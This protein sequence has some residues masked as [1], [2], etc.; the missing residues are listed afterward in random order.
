MKESEEK[1]KILVQTIPDI[2][3]EID[4]EGR[5]TFLS[6]AIKELGYNIIIAIL[7]IFPKDNFVPLHLYT[8]ILP[9]YITFFKLVIFIKQLLTTYFYDISNI[10]QASP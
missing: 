7:N 4:A 8:L 1:Y 6:D 5:L 10:I 9:L 2:V 3:Y